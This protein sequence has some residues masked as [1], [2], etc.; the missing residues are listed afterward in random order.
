MHQTPGRTVTLWENDLS[1]HSVKKVRDKIEELVAIDSTAWITLEIMSS[2]GECLPVYGLYD[3]IRGL[4]T[5]IQTIGYGQ[6]SSMAVILFLAGKHR[7]VASHCFFVIHEMAQTYTQNSRLD[8]SEHFGAIN[9]LVFWEKR[10]I[11]TI[12]QR[13]KRPPSKKHL[14]E[15]IKAETRLTAKDALEWGLAHEILPK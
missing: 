2:G 12:R 1:T 8:I 10:Y 5:P 4:N 15:M 11:K 3:W 14:E 13:C 6:V 9:S 7:V